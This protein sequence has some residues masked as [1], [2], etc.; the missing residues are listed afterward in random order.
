MGNM[1]TKKYGLQPLTYADGRNGY[2][3]QV[4][5]VVEVSSGQDTCILVVDEQENRSAKWTRKITF[6]EKECPTIKEAIAAYES[7]KENIGSDNGQNS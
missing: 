6:G 5:T 4:K 7:K 2:H 3:L 1:D